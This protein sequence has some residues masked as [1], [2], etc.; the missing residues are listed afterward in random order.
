MPEIDSKSWYYSKTLWGIAI[1]G[2]ASLVAYITKNPQV[3]GAVIA[4][5][6]S[7]ISVIS[8]C[9]AAVSGVLAIIGRVVAQSKLT[10]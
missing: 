9:I 10:K 4:E 5:S 3:E 2:I 8:V 7:I 1:A 6:P